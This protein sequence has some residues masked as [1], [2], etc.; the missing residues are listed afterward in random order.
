MAQ[1]PIA[2]I[3]PKHISLQLKKTIRV[4]RW[5]YLLQC[6]VRVFRRH[7]EVKEPRFALVQRFLCYSFKLLP[8]KKYCFFLHFLASLLS[9]IYNILVQYWGIAFSCFIL[10]FSSSF[11]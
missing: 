11:Y 3:P 8:L 6:T 10:A 7:Q 2:K 9:I 5:R 4:R 1:Q